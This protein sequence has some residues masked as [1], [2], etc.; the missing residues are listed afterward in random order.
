MNWASIFLVSVL[1]LGCLI[2]IVVLLDMLRYRD[3][4]RRL[5]EERERKAEK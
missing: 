3:L 5:R 2:G 4:Q 1:I